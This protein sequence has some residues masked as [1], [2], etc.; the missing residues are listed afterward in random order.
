MAAPRRTYVISVYDDEPSV[1][2]EAV[3]R[4]ERERLDSL[5]DL[6]ARI[7]RWEATESV[8]DQDDSPV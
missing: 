5:D 6:A 2:V 1:V 4:E 7:R 8:H 3:L